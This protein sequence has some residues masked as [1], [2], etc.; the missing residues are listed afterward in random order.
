M[1]PYILATSSAKDIEPYSIIPNNPQTY[2]LYLV[3]NMKRNKVVCL[4]D[5]DKIDNLLLTT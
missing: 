1:W 3:T 4:K 2:Y 5:D